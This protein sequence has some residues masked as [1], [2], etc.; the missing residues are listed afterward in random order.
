MKV[1][2]SGFDAFG[3]DDENPS[4]QVLSCLPSVIGVWQVHTVLLPTAARQ[5]T[6]RLEALVEQ[7]EPEVVLCMGQAK[8]RSQ[9][10]VER[11][12]INLDDF[13]IADNS[14]FRPTD[15]P[16][17]AEGPAAYFVRLPVKAM[18]CKIQAA[19]IPAALSCTAGTYVCNHVLYSISHFL[20]MRGRGQLNGFIHLP[21]LP[22]QVKDDPKVPSM[23]LKDQVK[24]VVAAIE[25]LDGPELKE[26]RGSIC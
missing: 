6:S 15:R 19:G 17:A 12:G 16:I 25:V 9:V 24:A 18:V 11:I 8:G 3:N 23:I 13:P 4:Q 1:L 10:T 26:S 22:S 2:V 14:G 5:A 20:E 7:L 21:C